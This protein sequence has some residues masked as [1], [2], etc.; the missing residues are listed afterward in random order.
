MRKVGDT[1]YFE[2]WQDLKMHSPIKNGTW[3]KSILEQYLIYS[4]NKK[5]AK[6]IDA[7]FQAYQHDAALAKLLFHFLLDE[8]YDGSDCQT[9]AAYYIAR[10][11]LELLRKNKALLYSTQSRNTIWQEYFS[12]IVKQL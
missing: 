4:C 8:N 3:K 9:G 1:M 6:Q 12:D 5:F 2:S 7:F 11:D 10:L